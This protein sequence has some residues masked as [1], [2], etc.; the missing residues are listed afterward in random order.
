MEAAFNGY[1]FKEKEV[2]TL[3]YLLFQQKQVTP[4]NYYFCKNR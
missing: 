2:M 1:L 4:F 3:N